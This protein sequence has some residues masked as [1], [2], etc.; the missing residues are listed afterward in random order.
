MAMKLQFLLYEVGH[1]EERYLVKVKWF[2]YL[3]PFH[4]NMLKGASKRSVF[5]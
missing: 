4:M 5:P 2:L 3:A 1:S